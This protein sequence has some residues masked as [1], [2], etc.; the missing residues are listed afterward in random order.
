MIHPE[1]AA[2]VAE[3]SKTGFSYLSGLHV[4]NAWLSKY[5]TLHRCIAV[6]S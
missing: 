3:A 2:G 4:L 1:P 6:H 5:S